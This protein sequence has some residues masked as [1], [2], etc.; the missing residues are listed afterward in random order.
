VLIDGGWTGKGVVARRFTS[1]PAAP[2]SRWS[3]S[4]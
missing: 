3:Q 2:Q 4:T 1:C